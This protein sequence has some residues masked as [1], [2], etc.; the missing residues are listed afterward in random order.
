LKIL[1]VVPSYLPATRYGGP[2][3]SVHGL[4]RAQAARGHDVKVF[5]TNV[6]GP[7][8]SPVSVGVPV[9]ISGVEVW[10]FPTSVGRR[11]YR[12]P[13]MAAALYHGGMSFDIVHLHSVFLWPTMMAARWA[14]STA[15]PYVLTPRG[16]LVADLIARKSRWLKRTWITCSSVGLLPA[17]RRYT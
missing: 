1:H 10:Y 9:D 12:S 14:T 15:T 3:R 7:T 16:M 11:L 4:A 2:I 8:V 5:T 6:D 13:A 17:R